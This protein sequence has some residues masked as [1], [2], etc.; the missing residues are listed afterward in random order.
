MHLK[1]AHILAVGIKYPTPE[2]VQIDIGEATLNFYCL[3]LPKLQA[4]FDASIVSC[5][6]QYPTAEG[7]QVKLPQTLYHCAN[8][9][10]V[11]G[12]W[13][14]RDPSALCDGT[15]PGESVRAILCTARFH[16]SATSMQQSANIFFQL[17]PRQ[18][19]TVRT[20]GQCE[21]LRGRMRLVSAYSRVRRCLFKCGQC[22][23]WCVD[24]RAARAASPTP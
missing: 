10:A 1:P 21:V 14:H 17:I 11:L 6:D 4:K 16:E 19:C 5:P 23:I 13:R 3:Y 8:R 24:T 22:E 12:Q 18:Y 7:S 20:D 15:T 9:F 2:L